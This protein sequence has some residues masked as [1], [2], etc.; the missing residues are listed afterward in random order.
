MY[1][2]INYIQWSNIAP[3]DAIIL[4]GGGM[5]DNFPS[6]QQAINRML[7]TCGCV[8]AWGVG[9]HNYKGQAPPLP[10]IDYT[11]FALITVRDFEYPVKLE[12]LPCVTCLL[13]QLRKKQEI[14]RAIGVINHPTYTITGTDFDTIDNSLGIDEIT[15]FIAQSEA[16]LTTSYHAAYWALLM[17]KK[18][19]VGCIWA[20]KFEY[21]ERKPVILEELSTDVLNNAVSTWDAKLY[22]GWLDECISLNFKFFER[23][24][25]LLE[26]YFPVSNENIAGTLMNLLKQ[27]AWSSLPIY[28]QLGDIVEQTNS[29]VAE[30]SQRFAQIEQK[31]DSLARDIMNIGDR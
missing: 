31:C 17:G 29:V 25:N 28:K 8:I 14:K 10:E 15:G 24:K 26:E 27:Q 9:F 4:G 21:F 11:K 1:H 13:P 22:D 30:I 5:L 2:H 19:I 7:N 16:I 12:Y 3:C 6:W 18:T 20:N 23:V